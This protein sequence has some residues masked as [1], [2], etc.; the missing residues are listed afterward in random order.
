MSEQ[1]TT[2]QRAATTAANSQ[3]IPLAEIDRDPSNP[4]KHFDEDALTDLAAS[5]TEHGVI[6][7]IVVRPVPLDAEPRLV[8]AARYW[9][10]AG[11]RRWRASIQAGR[12][13][14]PAIVREDLTAD[15]VAMLQVIENLQ[16]ADLSLH[17]TAAGVSHLVA[18][19]GNTEAARQLGKSAAWISKHAN[20]AT[21]DP[22]VV[23]LVEGGQLTSADM[24]HDLDTLIERCQEGVDAGV[25]FLESRA[26]SVLDLATRGELRRSQLRDHLQRTQDDIAYHL[27]KGLI[28]SAPAQTPSAPNSGRTDDLPLTEPTNPPT[29]EKQ[30]ASTPQ[31]A[32]AQATPKAG[33]QPA[34]QPDATIQQ[35][36]A[37]NSAMAARIASTFNRIADAI[38]ADATGDVDEWECDDASRYVHQS[39]H[40]SGLIVGAFLPPPAQQDP[41][42]DPTETET[43]PLQIQLELAPEQAERLVAW[44]EAGGLDCEAPAA[45]AAK[46]FDSGEEA[47]EHFIA[48]CLADAPGESVKGGAISGAYTRYCHAH[49]VEPITSWPLISQRL[50]AAGYEHKRKAAGKFYL[51]CALVDA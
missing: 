12:E 28:P 44:I 14:I 9:I 35:S 33:E 6:Q 11:E 36:A 10:V 1:I 48:E 19:V 43:L 27:R 32:P 7:P 26:A 51:N 13:S 50:R 18:R 21:L 17:E 40:E 23:A 45:T 34:N 42:A 29:G 37:P 22:R 3:A 31:E 20:L 5:I 30:A 38:G 47:L 8:D 24:A 41:G 46:T 39:D 49:G 16:R 2:E 25:S 4:R 15:Q